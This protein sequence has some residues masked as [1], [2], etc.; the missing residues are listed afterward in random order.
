MMMM[1]IT[2]TQKKK[3]ICILGFSESWANK[4]NCFKS[5]GRREVLTV[6]LGGSNSRNRRNC[7]LPIGY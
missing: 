7:S 1:T 3:K 6:Q 5:V 4:A 2:T